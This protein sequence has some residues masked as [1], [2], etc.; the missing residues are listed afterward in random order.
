MQRRLAFY[1]RR[2][3][4]RRT[5]DLSGKSI[6]S[7]FPPDSEFTVYDKDLWYSD[8]WDPLSYGRDFDFSRPFFEQFHDL[9]KATP[10]LSVAVVGQNENSEFTNDNQ[11]L[12][13]C[14]LVFDCGTLFALLDR[15]VARLAKKAARML[16]ERG[17]GAP[18][19]ESGPGARGAGLAD[20]LYPWAFRQF[21]ATCV[22]LQKQGP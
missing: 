15:N 17:R 7:M 9:M 20:W 5:C 6:V 3:L 11:R 4:Y 2:R 1:N 16:L 13:N 14:Y 8:A 10:Y 22:V 19:P 12:K 21:Q 18:A